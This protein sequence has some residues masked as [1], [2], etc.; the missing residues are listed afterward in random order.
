[1]TR[2]CPKCSGEYQDWV[3]KCVDCGE[4]L[5]DTKP[6]P[7]S[8]ERDEPKIITRGDRRYTKGEQLVSAASFTNAIEAQFAKGI[9][10]SEGIDSM[11]VSADTIIAYQPDATSVGS[12]QLLVKESEAEAAKEILNSVEK[13]ITEEAIIETEFD[14]QDSPKPDL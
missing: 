6:E 14:D 10:E 13:N 11:V 5:V 3:E 7:Q 1:M 8:Q 12:I 2:Y 4:K 9:L